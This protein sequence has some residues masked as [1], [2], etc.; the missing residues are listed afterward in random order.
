MLFLLQ[1]NFPLVVPS[2]H[3]L[4]ANFFISQAMADLT[5]KGI[6]VD[7]HYNQRRKRCSQL[8]PLL[9][10][11]TGRYGSASSSNRPSRS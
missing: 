10:L 6:T 4:Q 5:P 3:S 1:Q 7:T 9:L 2:R 8:L 11:S